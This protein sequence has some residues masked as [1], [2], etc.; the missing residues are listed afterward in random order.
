MKPPV[1][2]TC[3]TLKTTKGSQTLSGFVSHCSN[4]LFNLLP[5]SSTHRD[6]RFRS[7]FFLRASA[8]IESYAH[9]VHP[10]ASSHHIPFFWLTLHAL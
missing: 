3:L 5:C 6:S 10:S 8:L 2:N 4:H 7:S 1:V 9:K